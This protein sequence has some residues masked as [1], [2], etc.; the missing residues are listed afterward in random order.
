MQA[1]RF[2]VLLADLNIGQASD[3][4]TLARTM[5]QINPQCVRLILTGSP[6][7]DSAIDARSPP[8]RAAP[9]GWRVNALDADRQKSADLSSI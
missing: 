5:R 7:L 6:A 4:I 8:M 2:D 1:G 3:G 9:P